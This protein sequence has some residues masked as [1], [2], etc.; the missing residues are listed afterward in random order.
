MSA[1][2]EFNPEEVEALVQAVV[3]TFDFTL[4]GK[5]QSLGRDLAVTAAEGIADRSNQG[6]DAAGEPFKPN[7][8]KYAA[9]KFRKFQVDRPGELGGQTLSLQSVLGTPEVTPD[10]VVMRYGTGQAPQRKTSRGGADLSPSQLEATDQEKA[11]WLQAGG[12]EFYGL[13]AE[14]SE[15]VIVQAGDALTE[16]LKAGGL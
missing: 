2:F 3:D 9:Y 14:I 13:D 1:A 15:K 5:S 12:R 4:P 8:A 6:L 7:A 16:H 10:T 11:E